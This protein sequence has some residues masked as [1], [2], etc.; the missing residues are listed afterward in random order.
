[1][2]TLEQRKR[3]VELYIQYAHNGEAVR[4]E[5]GYP[6]SSHLIKKWYEEGFFEIDPLAKEGHFNG[7]YTSADEKGKAVEYYLNCGRNLAKTIRDL[8]VTRSALE[9]WID[10]LAPGQRRCRGGSIQFH[11]IEKLRRREEASEDDLMEDR[12]MHEDD[13]LKRSEDPQSDIDK[14]LTH[15]KRELALVEEKLR[16]KQMELDL[17]CESHELLKKSPG[18]DLENLKNKEKAVL[19]DALRCKYELNGLLDCLGL[20][21]S[22]FFYQRKTL[23]Q[24]DKYAHLRIRI[25][26]LFIDLDKRFGYRTIGALLRREKKNVSE[27]VVR[28]IMVE[29]DLRVILKRRRRYSSYIGE[30]NPSAKNI[31]KRDFSANSPNGKWLTDLTEFKIPAGKIYLS[32]IIDCFDGKVVSWTMGTSP[33]AELVNTMLDKAMAILGE[34]EHPL[35]HSDRGCHYRWPGW[36]ERMEKAG[37][38]RSMSKKGC[39]PDNA[40]CEGFFGRLKNEFFYYRSWKGVSVKQFMSMLDDYLSWYNEK[41]IK[42]SLGWMSPV[43]YRLSKSLAA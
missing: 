14:N 13:D 3:A 22:T 12:D 8:K 2:F 33:N 1:M 30:S 24:P 15:A 29:E 40:A 37:L 26:E 25:G 36:I 34:N 42:K 17:A 23:R 19:V 20:A 10:E 32:P 35:I 11:K 31:I 7:Y 28:R 18:V 9:R 4:K 43:E 27:K 38:K 39:S 16:Q 21:R 41:R 5:L 6:S